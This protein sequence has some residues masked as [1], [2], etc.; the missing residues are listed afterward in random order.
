MKRWAWL[1]VVPVAVG[2]AVWLTPDTTD[3]AII[4]AI[5]PDGTIEWVEGEIRRAEENNS[6]AHETGSPRTSKLAADVEIRTA[7]G[8]GAPHDIDL[9]LFGLGAVPC[10]KAEFLALLSPPY[11][12]QLTFNG[13][14]EITE[15]AG[16][17]HP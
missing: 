2:V 5:H 9:S 17:Y 8:C 12:P 14:G 1:A 4:T 13:D 7:Q 15:I 11:A 6:A 3:V 16:R 10:T